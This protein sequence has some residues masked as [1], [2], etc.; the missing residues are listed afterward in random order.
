MPINT[1]PFI[2]ENVICA[3]VFVRKGDKYLLIK[4][5]EDKKFAPGVIHPI[6]GKVDQNED[7][8]TAAKR[9]VFEEAGI[10]IKNMRLEAVILEINPPDDKA[11]DKN[12]LIFHFSADYAS[13]KV[14]QNE[15]G[16]LVLLS[17]KEIKSQKLFPSVKVV[18]DDI[19]NPGQGTVFMTTIYNEKGEVSTK[20]TLISKCLV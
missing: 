2:H 18:I 8:F 7:P 20:Q 3:N 5:R 4:R 19:L 6:G 17:S 1:K 15:E 9:E 12:W 10:K 14:K 16:E 13:G 11:G